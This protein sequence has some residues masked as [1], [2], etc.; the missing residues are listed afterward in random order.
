MSSQK[1]NFRQ[2]RPQSLRLT[3]N[4]STT[5]LFLFLRKHIFTLARGFAKNLEGYDKTLVNHTDLSSQRVKYKPA[6]HKYHVLKRGVRRCIPVLVPQAGERLE[7]TLCSS[8]VLEHGVRRCIPV[9]VPQAGERLEQTLCPPRVLEHG[10]RRC[11]PV[12]VPQAGERL[13]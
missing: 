8:W 4:K 10:V 3:K 2:R 1:I 7:Q 9:L 11:I 12:L 6:S 13:E 5:F